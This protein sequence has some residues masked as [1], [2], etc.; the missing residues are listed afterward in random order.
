M[1]YW[2]LLLPFYLLATIVAL[3]LSPILPIFAE[4]RLGK[5]DNSSKLLVEPRLPNWL[6]WFMTQDNS[7]WGDSG[8]RTI[9]CQ[10]WNSYAGMVKWLLRNP[11]QGIAWS[12]FSYQLPPNIQLHWK[13][14]GLNVDKAPNCEGW[15][16]ITLEQSTL[17]SG[18]HYRFYRVY[19]IKCWDW[20]LHVAFYFDVGWLLHPYLR[21]T[22]SYGTANNYALYQ[23]QPKLKLSIERM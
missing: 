17:M 11:G 9:H 18:F 8:W 12:V 13:G 5:S 23:F 22:E 10:N 16:F 21:S 1:F 2:L 4:Y 6:N 7:L 15:F 3:I 19:G 20:R 14:T